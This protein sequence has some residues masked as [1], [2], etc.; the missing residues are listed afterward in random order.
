MRDWNAYAAPFHS[1]MP[2]ELVTVNR[3]VAEQLFGSVVDFG[4]GPGKV[5]PFALTTNRVNGYLGVDMSPEMVKCARWVASHY[6]GKPCKIV[7][8]KIEHYSLSSKADSALSINSY[9]TWPDPMR[10]LRHIAS[11][12]KVD[13]SFVLATINASLDMNA[14]LEEAEKEQL[15]NPYWQDFK[16]Y[17]QAIFRCN[18]FNLATLDEL[19]D[20]VRQVGFVVRDAHTKFY[21]GGLNYLTLTKGHL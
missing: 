9:Y 21:A 16:R 14:L 2:S 7:Q 8:A 5:I 20:Q 15:A 3:S 10:I 13:G 17:N 1:V 19:V 11:Q 4:C 12:L 6:P 18:T